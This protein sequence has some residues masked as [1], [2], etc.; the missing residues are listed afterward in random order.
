MNQRIITLTRY[1]F[2]RIAR[3]VVGGL[4]FLSALALWLIFFNPTQ[5]RVPE[6]D[7]FI[8]LVTIY[9]ALLSFLTTLSV[10]T[11]ANRPESAALITRLPSRVEYLAAILLSCLSFSL[12][13]QVV[14]SI[15]VLL[16]PQGPSIGFSK[17]IEIPPIWVATNIFMI[18]LALH[19]S[20]FVMNGWSRAYVFAVLT[21]LLFSQSV[22]SRGIKWVSDRLNGFATSA[23]R[24]EWVGLAQTLRNASIWVTNNGLDFMS[25]TIGF[26]FWPF[27]AISN[28]VQDGFFDNAQILAP[29]ILLL[30]AT[31]LFMLAADLFANKDLHFVE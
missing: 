1:L 24:Q 11:R 25:Q 23:T 7:Y 9:G 21:A 2:H 18:V 6:P 4:Y 3:S 26:V 13:I 31:I 17:L 29:A 15:V 20:D 30:Y 12:L 10:S 8:L 14:I 28:A 5:S 19:A 27:R 16:Q 22:D